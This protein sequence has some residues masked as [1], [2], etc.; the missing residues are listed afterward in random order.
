MN[1]EQ[2][3]QK[4]IDETSAVLKQAFEPKPKE[5]PKK[6]NWA[7]GP[8]RPKKVVKPKEVKAAVVMPGPDAT[9]AI[10]AVIEN[11]VIEVAF[12]E[13]VLWKEAMFCVMGNLQVKAPQGIKACIATADEFV[14]VYKERWGV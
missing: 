14:N 12:N 2:V 3:D 13:Q 4:R 10:P 5:E 8:G 1:E 7:P 11:E 6:T 9:V